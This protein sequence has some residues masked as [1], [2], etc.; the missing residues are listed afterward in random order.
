MQN[1]N[2]KLIPNPAKNAFQV[3]GIPAKTDV[4]AENI[5]STNN[6][7]KFFLILISL[8]VVALIFLLYGFLLRFQID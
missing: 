5:I 1:Q 7:N 8:K 6:T 4:K 3:V 2:T